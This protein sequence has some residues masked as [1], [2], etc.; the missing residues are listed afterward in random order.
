M[1]RLLR[2]LVLVG[3]S[4]LPQDA[5]AKVVAGGQIEFG[6]HTI[7]TQILSAG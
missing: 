6:G 2:I 5:A 4:L 3:I 7:I 1:I